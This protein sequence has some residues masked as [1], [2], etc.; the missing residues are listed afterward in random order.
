MTQ[1]SS[2]NQPENRGRPKGSPNRAKQL[3]RSATPAILEALIESA[4]EGDTQAATTVL[5]YS[6]PS[7]K[8]ESGRLDLT[9]PDGATLA[10]KAE[11]VTQAALT[12]RCCPSVASALI[13]AIAQTVKIHE[14]DE[15]LT[16]L[17]KLE[18]EI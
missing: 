10:Q 9:V 5:K 2:S 13:G 1:F 7:V 15:I 4:K 17:D 12:G 18:S 3:I 6:M 16:R 14:V 11:L 8:P